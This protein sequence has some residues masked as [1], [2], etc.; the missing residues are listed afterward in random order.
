MDK[1]LKRWEELNQLKRD[2]IK[3]QADILSRH[4]KRTFTDENGNLH[5]EYEEP[6]NNFKA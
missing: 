1:D 5:R 4:V 6:Y 3:E 2:I